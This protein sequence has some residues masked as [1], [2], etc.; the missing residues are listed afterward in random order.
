AGVAGTMAG[1]LLIDLDRSTGLKQV[2]DTLGHAVGDRLLQIVAHR[3]EHSV[4]PG[5]V[6]ARLGGD[7][8]AVLLPSVREAAAAREVASRLRAALAEPVRLQAITFQ[9]ESTHALAL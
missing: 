5:D 2:N 6:V 7:E 4:R 1:F 3:L 8:F 9:P